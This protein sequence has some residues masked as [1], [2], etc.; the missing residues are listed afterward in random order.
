MGRDHVGMPFEVQVRGPA[1][2]V[3]GVAHVAQEGPRSDAAARSRVV[4]EVGAVGVPLASVQ[5]ERVAPQAVVVPREPAGE[6]RD[7]RRAARR[8]EVDA[9]VR[10]VSARVARGAEA[11]G[12]GVRAANGARHE[13]SVPGR[14]RTGP[15]T[16]TR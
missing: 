6:W 9:G 14:R 3:A 5:Q 15:T 1:P 11:V 7:D 8:H 12:V 2:R 13:R 10:M 16:G 4:V